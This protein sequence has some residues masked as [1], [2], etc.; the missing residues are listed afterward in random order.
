LDG[1]DLRDSEY[2]ARRV[3]HQPRALRTA[4]AAAALALAHCARE[5]GCGAG[6]HLRLRA[7]RGRRSRSFSYTALGKGVAALFATLLV[8]AAVG[9]Y[10][11]DRL[12][13]VGLYPLLHVTLIFAA[14]VCSQLAIAALYA[15]HRPTSRRLGRL[16]H[17]R[18]ALVVG[19][20]LITAG[21]F[22]ARQVGRNEMLRFVVFERTA[23]Q[24]KLMGVASAAGLIPA[25]EP[26][27]FVEPSAETE[28]ELP[29]GPRLRD[30]N[31]LLLTVDA[32]RADQMGVY[33]ASRE[34]TPRLDEW[35]RGS[36]VFERGYCPTPVTSFSLT[37]LLTGNRVEGRPRE[38][39]SRHCLR[40]C[41]G[42]ATKRGASFLHRYSISI[43]PAST[44]SSRLTSISS[45]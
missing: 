21:S 40:C 20:V 27:V 29:P 17:P 33:G 13:L 28:R 41:V 4:C 9:F 26:E 35:A 25:P 10:A 36:V 16:L 37:S 15:A 19:V 34:L 2:A 3:R 42:T 30:A 45:M 12:V 1:A 14:A 22:A 6:W 7:A 5:R 39:T 24:Q 23:L 8:G 32:L 31:V 44:D 11:A 38:R 18:L 43:G